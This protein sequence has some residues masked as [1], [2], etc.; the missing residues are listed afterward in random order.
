MLIITYV[1]FQTEG[2]REPHNE[3]GSL[4]PTERLAG[5]HPGT[6]RFLHNALTH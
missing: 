6:F 3:F 5:F 2:Q 4:R 1:K